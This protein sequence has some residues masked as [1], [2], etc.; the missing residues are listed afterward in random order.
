MVK[1]IWVIN[2]RNPVTG[3]IIETAGVPYDSWQEADAA[4]STLLGFRK[5]LTPTI[6]REIV[7]LT[8]GS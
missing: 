2:W 3:D 1:N 7:E 8:Y 4:L 6:D 5:T